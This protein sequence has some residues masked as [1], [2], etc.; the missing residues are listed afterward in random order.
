MYKLLYFLGNVRRNNTY[1]F[2][3]VILKLFFILH[4]CKVGRGLRCHSFPRFRISPYKNFFIGDKVTIGDNIT[5]EI[6]PS[7]H[8]TL[9]NNVKLTQQILISSGKE[10][11][12]GEYSIFAEN[13]SIRDGDHN[14]AANMPVS[15]QSTSFRPI[16][17]GKDVWIGA[18]TLILKGSDIP[19]GVVIGANSVVL[20]GLKLERNHVYAGSPVK[21]IR[22]RE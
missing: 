7:G 22:V 9:G 21:K 17:I 14:T 20:H 4:G 3:R 15:L 16:Q 10:I 18:G 8:L 1:K 19:D 13:V 5:F 6:L 2:K 11:N 12:I